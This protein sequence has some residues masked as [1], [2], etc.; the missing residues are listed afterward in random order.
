MFLT[1]VIIPDD[2]RVGDV[3][4]GWKLPTP[5][6]MNERVALGGAAAPQRESEPIASLTQALART[7]RA[8]DP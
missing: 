6:L 3:G 1:D 5:R 7:P 2:M 4:D 8:S